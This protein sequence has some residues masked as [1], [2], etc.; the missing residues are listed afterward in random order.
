MGAYGHADR[1]PGAIWP[2]IYARTIARVWPRLKPRTRDISPDID[3]ALR[4]L[5]ESR[6]RFS[7]LQVGAY[8]GISN[9]PLHHLIRAYGHVRAVL[10][11]P[12]P[13]P[14]AALEA[15]WRDCPRVVT[16]RCALA[17]DCGARP[18][19]V[20]ADDRRHLHPFSDQIASFS[21]EYVEMECSR[22]V[23]RPLRDMVV[24][25]PVPTVDW[26][27][28]AREHGPFDLVSIDAEGYDGEVLHQMDLTGAPP[29]IIRYEHRHLSREM[30][31]RCRDL[32]EQAGYRL[33]QV[34]KAD[35]LAARVALDVPADGGVG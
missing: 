14:Y 24:S 29:D 13:A 4:A 19:Y 26:G 27:T 11:E 31:Q 32:L 23:W 3:R 34:N 20:I 1:V 10:V 17:A 15:L 33:R 25:M 16:L 18:L 2:Y 35:T 9:D 28:L 8:D 5:V 21:R 7:V 6:E 30:R 22:Y 12:Q